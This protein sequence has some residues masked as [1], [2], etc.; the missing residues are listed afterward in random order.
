MVTRAEEKNFYGALATDYRFDRVLLQSEKTSFEADIGPV[1]SELNIFEHIDKPYLTGSLLFADQSNYFEQADFLGTEKLNIKITS[2]PKLEDTVLSIEKNFIVTEIVNATR[3]NDLTEVFLL[4]FVEDISYKSRLIRVSKSFTGRPQDIIQSIV[5]QYLQREVKVILDTEYQEPKPMKVVVPNMTPIEAVSWIK[6]R[7]STQ[8]G[9]PF[10]LFSTICD[11][12]LRYVDL[13]TILSNQPLNQDRTYI[14]SQ[15]FARDLS[16]F[17]EVEQA[18][19]IQSYRATKKENQLDLARKGLVGA[20]YNFVDT[21]VGNNVIKRFNVN[22]IFSTL[23]EQNI[24][25]TNQNRQIFDSISR[26]DDRPMQQYDTREITQIVSSNTYGD[27]TYNYNESKG[28]NSHMLKATSKSMRH[29]LHKSSIDINVP[30][31]NF[32]YRDTNKTIG[33]NIRLYFRNNPENVE[34]DEARDVKRSGEYMIYAA[35][36]VFSG[37]KYNVNLSCVK[38]ANEERN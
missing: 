10:F 36:H 8:I 21:T 17:N 37:N 3:A 7:A 1:V 33:N 4:N 20:T 18:Y 29:F 6:D 30:G 32:L 26:I 13:G 24:I 25:K 9:M 28:I 23:K 31:Q 19:I 35:R 16:N 34:Y 12:R 2:A 15:A 5:N 11:D 27:D 38:L 22:D 14:H